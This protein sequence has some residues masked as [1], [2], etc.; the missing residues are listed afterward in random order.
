MRRQLTLLIGIISLTIV[1]IAGTVLWKNEPLL[2]LDLQGGVSVRLIA[3]QPA[4]EIMLDQTVEIIRNRVDGLGVA[5]PEI[6]RIEGG[7]MVSLPGVKDQD[8]ALQ[9]VG[10]T[11]EMRFRPV[12]NVFPT[13]TNGD[14]EN[15]GNNYSSTPLASC[16][17]AIT[18]EINPVVGADGITPKDSD[19]AEN[20]VILSSQDDPGYSYLLGP[21]VLT[22]DG[23]SDAGADFYD[24]Q[25]QISLVLKEG[26]NG[27]QAFN[28]IS[29]QCYVGSDSCPTLP[30]FSN[31]R[32]A[33]VLDGEIITAPQI[34]APEFQRDAIVITGAYE[35]EEAENVALALRYGSLPVE[36]EAENT[37]L[38]S[39]T[40][41]EDSLDAGVKA[42]IIGLVLVALFMLS[43]YRLL[44][45]VALSS[46][47]I[48]GALLWAIIAHLGTQEGLAL[49]LAGITGIIVSIG[50]SVDSNIVYFE[51]LK[52]DV[53]DGRTARS[54]VDRAFPV[55]FSTIVKA[56]VASLIGA[57]LLWWLTVGAVKGFAFYL[58]L[59]T[60]LDLVATYF[61]M[62]PIVKVLARTNW[63]ANHPK[64]FGLPA[65]GAVGESRYRTSSTQVETV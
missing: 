50:V 15:E 29:A 2:G 16:T 24:Y 47:L 64:R 14:I 18:G 19:L 17:G 44:G 21:S 55:A 49:T 53:L 25:W 5:E 31:G 58:G 38:V 61:F 20:F 46:L 36:L 41:G 13:V 57:V 3:T 43:Y 4:D 28:S 33:I 56:D 11:A 51:H 62:G 63:F 59:A 34:R 54:S 30:G 37:Q 40:I 35:K 9:L 7:V 23:L 39:A 60:L 12:C 65:S 52:E 26:Q 1:S 6:S 27:I 10:T 32:L 8:R 22:G 48:S 42:G 45:L